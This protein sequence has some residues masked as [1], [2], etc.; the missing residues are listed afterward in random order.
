MIAHEA[1]TGITADLLA[2]SIEGQHGKHFAVDWT[3]VLRTTGISLVTDDLPFLVWGR[4]LW[5]SVENLKAKVRASSL[6]PWKK[7]FLTNQLTV[8]AGKMLVTQLVYET[9][10]DSAYLSMQAL[11]LKSQLPSGFIY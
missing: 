9:I 2:Q 4:H 5:N 8:S 11:M 3:R 6:S 1:F 10:S 7:A